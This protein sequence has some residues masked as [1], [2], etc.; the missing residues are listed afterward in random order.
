VTRSATWPEALRRVLFLGRVSAVLCFCALCCLADGLQSLM[1]EDFNHV[2]LAAGGRTR[3]SGAMPA[4]LKDHTELEVDIEGDADLRFT[5]LSSF[6]GFWMGVFM[7]RAELEAGAVPGTAELVVRDMV[8]AKNVGKN[9]TILVQN[10]AQV[11][12]VTVWPSEEALRAAHPSLVHRLTACSPFVFAVVCVAGG[13]AFGL[14]HAVC[15]HKLQRALARQG[16]FFIHGILRNAEG[17]RAVFVPEN[18]EDIRPGADVALLTPEGRETGGSG[19]AECGPK[20]CT[21]LFPPGGA[22]PRYGMIL[23]LEKKT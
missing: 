7:W 21:V 12:S 8:P 9:A 15:F 17:V 5:P 13:I 23:R 22:Q 11:Y 1:R 2:A 6:R 18:T 19:R 3:L 20:R 14:L 16:L 10:P 4:N